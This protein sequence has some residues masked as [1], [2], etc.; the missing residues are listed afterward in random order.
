MALEV[1]KMVIEQKEKEWPALKVWDSI[2]AD[3]IVLEQAGIAATVDTEKI[4]DALGRIYGKIPAL[5]SLIDTAGR[6]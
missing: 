4:R 3:V 1:L 6:N 5:V 2:A